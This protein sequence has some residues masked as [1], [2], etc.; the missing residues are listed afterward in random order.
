MS[1]LFPYRRPELLGALTATSPFSETDA[2]KRI[3]GAGQPLKAA[4]V[5]VREGLADVAR[6]LQ[7]VVT[8]PLPKGEASTRVSAR[9]TEP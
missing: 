1:G 4:G 8:E 3:V 9:L 2:A 7:A 5:P 6:Q